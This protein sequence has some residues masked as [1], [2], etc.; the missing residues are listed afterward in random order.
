MN[1]RKM[2]ETII[3]MR[4]LEEEQKLMELMDR[5]KNLKKE[6]TFIDH[7]KVRQEERAVRVKRR[8]EER[9]ERKKD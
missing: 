3:K 9:K 8:W 5:K 4:S 6:S 2:V 7:T 1:R